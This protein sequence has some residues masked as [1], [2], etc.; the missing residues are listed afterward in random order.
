MQTK[1]QHTEW[2]RKRREGAQKG[3]QEVVKGAQIIE[4][5]AQNGKVHKEG[6]HIISTPNGGYMH[7]EKLVDIGWRGLISYL[8]ENLKPAY[9]GSLRIGMS[10]PTVG[11][12]RILLEATA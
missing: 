5:G 10:G 7:I 8:V 3:A 2:M 11:E 12:C 6:A 9:Q 4:K 1:E